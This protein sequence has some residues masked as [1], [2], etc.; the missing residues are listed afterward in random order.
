MCL[1]A[2]VRWDLVR[3]EDVRKVCRRD[4][5]NNDASDYEM[6][7]GWDRIQAV[8]NPLDDDDDAAE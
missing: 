8:L 1:G 7:D 3:S 5:V 6:E 2:G 4:A